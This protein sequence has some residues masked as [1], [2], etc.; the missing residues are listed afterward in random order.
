M[1][2]KLS[3]DCIYDDHGP[4]EQRRT[5]QYLLVPIDFEPRLERLEQERDAL[6]EALK[7][8]LRDARFVGTDLSALRQAKDAIAEV[9]GAS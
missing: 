8:V 4:G 1:P 7:A 2:A 9:E 6:L 5:H 3:D